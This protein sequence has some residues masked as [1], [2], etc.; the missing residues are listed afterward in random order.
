M[1]S[2]R[3]ATLWHPVSIDRNQPIL[4]G[5]STKNIERIVDVRTLL[6]K[7]EKSVPLASNSTNYTN[8][9]RKMEVLLLKLSIESIKICSPS[10]KERNSKVPTLQPNNEVVSAVCL[11]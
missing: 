2:S 4:E 8:K 11:M 7:L 10:K 6:F 1:D 9:P 3:M 5:I